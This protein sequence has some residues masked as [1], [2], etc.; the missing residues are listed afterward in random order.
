M[1]EVIVRLQLHIFSAAIRI[2][3]IIINFYIITIFLLYYDY[4]LVLMRVSVKRLCVFDESLFFNNNSKTITNHNWTIVE[5]E[6]ERKL[7]KTLRVQI[8]LIWTF[9]GL[10]TNLHL[11]I[12][13]VAVSSFVR[14][15]TRSER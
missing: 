3:V 4:V 6:N 13:I 14:S 7:V 1:T 10:S 8:V 9:N 12:V 11:P 2:L 5:I 15:R